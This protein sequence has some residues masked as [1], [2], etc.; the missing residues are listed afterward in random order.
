MTHIVKM[1]KNSKTY[2]NYILKKAEDMREIILDYFN[3]E[4]DFDEKFAFVEYWEEVI[5]KH[6]CI[7][8]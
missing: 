1:F 2:H 3:Q 6:V 8:Y 4:I 7:V 5:L